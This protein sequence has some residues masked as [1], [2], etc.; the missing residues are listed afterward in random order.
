MNLE[1]LNPLTPLVQGAVEIIGRLIPDPQKKAEMQLEVL[2]LNQA[3]EFKELDAQ[4]QLALGQIDVNKV[5]AGSDSLF[6]SGW[7]PAA[8]WTCVSALCY[9]MVARPL[10]GWMAA[11]L[12]GWTDPPPLEVDTLMT[13][14]FGLLGLGYYRSREKM[15]GVK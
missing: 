14:L 9:Q 4:T 12:W 11:N 2:K 5:E 7:R 3:G 15:A 6:K 8:G 13:L 10:F 1:K